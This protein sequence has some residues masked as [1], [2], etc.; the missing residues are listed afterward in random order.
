MYPGG[1][2]QAVQVVVFVV[3]G[4]IPRFEKRLL[5]VQGD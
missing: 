4:S 3:S 5:V 1:V 2:R